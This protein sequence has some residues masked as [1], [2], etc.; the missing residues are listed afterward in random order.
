[1]GKKTRGEWLCFSQ[2]RSPNYHCWDPMIRAKE[3]VVFDVHS[4]NANLL[5][6]RDTTYISGLVYS[7]LF[8]TQ[9]TFLF[10]FALLTYAK[11]YEFFRTSK[12]FLDYLWWWT[13]DSLTNRTCRG[14][15]PGG[16]RESG[17]T[18]VDEYLVGNGDRFGYMDTRIHGSIFLSQNSGWNYGKVKIWRSRLWSVKMFLTCTF[19]RSQQISKFHPKQRNEI[20]GFLL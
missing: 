4:I 18:T 6:V 17:K 9:P 3:K 12:I 16:P 1:M 7:P 15:W 10:F 2:G 19:T 5:A 13:I 20:S 14:W 8:G 11:I